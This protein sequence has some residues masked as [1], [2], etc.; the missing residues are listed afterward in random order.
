MNS[1]KTMGLYK[2]HNITTV[3]YGKYTDVIRVIATKE[4]NFFAS[5]FS[6]A[7]E[8]IFII[9][10]DS[11]LLKTF[12]SAKQAGTTCFIN[13]NSFDDEKKN[14]TVYKVESSLALYEKRKSDRIAE[15]NRKAEE[16]RKARELQA[17][18]ERER[19]EAEERKKQEEAKTFEDL[20][21]NA[22]VHEM[23]WSG[24]QV[25]VDEDASFSE[26][27]AGIA[28]NVNLSF[29][30]G[31]NK[32]VTDNLV[33]L[34]NKVHGYNSHLLKTLAAKEGQVVGLAFIK[35]ALFFSNGDFQINEIAAQNAYY[36]IVKNF[37][38]TKNT[39]ALP[40]LFTLLAKKPQTLADELYSVNPDSS[41]AGLG[42]L[43]PSA[44]YRRKDQ[45]MMNRLPIMK[46]ILT[47]FYDEDK[48]TF[49]LDTTLPYHIPSQ[50]DVSK[51]YSDLDSSGLGTS[52]EV[53][54]AG[55]EYFKDLYDNIEEQL[56][57]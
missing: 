57:L 46:Y 35:M 47:K 56:D 9:S 36:C 48:K 28:G 40:A 26:Q 27:M 29:V 32:G 13:E 50:E 17:R 6:S 11:P 43:T 19:R 34:Y 51:F 8:T 30:T 38:V 20:L 37:L 15:A 39:Y 24:L 5:L 16:E 10:E 14:G 3:S 18:K 45:A 44:P 4:R 7:K 25:C 52:K 21:K 53:Y 54:E 31:N 33:I 41:L 23:P 1:F 12:K 2:I 49:L 55:E 42:G 22:T